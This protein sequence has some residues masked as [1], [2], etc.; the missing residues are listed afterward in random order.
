MS[1]RD[2]TSGWLSISVYHHVVPAFWT[3]MPTK[4]GATH[5]FSGTR[6]RWREVEA[7]LPWG[8]AAQPVEC[9]ETNI[10]RQGQK[11]A[12]YDAHW[13]SLPLTERRM[14]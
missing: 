3:P 7:R 1:W 6:H 9:R 13:V 12:P 14:P 8:V 4:S 2:E 10:G 5:L 11:T